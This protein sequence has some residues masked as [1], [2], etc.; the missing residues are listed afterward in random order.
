MVAA[1]TS[2]STTSRSSAFAD[3]L[4]LTPA[5]IRHGEGRAPPGRRRAG[6]GGGPVPGSR[7]VRP[8]P[9]RRRNSHLRIHPGDWRRRED[10]N[11]WSLSGRRFSKPLHSAALPRLRFVARSIASWCTTLQ[12]LVEKQFRA[13][14]SV[15]K[16]W[17]HS[18]RS[19]AGRCNRMSCC[20]L[21]EGTPEGT[22]LSGALCD[23]LLARVFSLCE[24][25]EQV[26]GRHSSAR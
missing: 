4:L 19:G 6:G 16:S 24:A 13:V 1:T 10:S 5:V 8:T 22:T 2:G 18:T 17:S 15:A 23:F 9:I 26:A 7:S 14:L 11:P 20:D 12:V 25:A 3:P 21:C